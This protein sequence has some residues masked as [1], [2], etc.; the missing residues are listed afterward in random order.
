MD[1]KS[2][3]VSGV[4]VGDVN[5][6]I[7]RQYTLIIHIEVVKKLGAEVEGEKLPLVASELLEEVTEELLVRPCARSVAPWQAAVCEFAAYKQ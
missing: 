1:V 4:A 5:G 2:F 7:D 6:S 3:Y